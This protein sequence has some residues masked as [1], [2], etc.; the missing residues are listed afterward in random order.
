MSSDGIFPSAT[1]CMQ[2][3]CSITTPNL[4]KVLGS[5]VLT[6]VIGNSPLSTKSR[7]I[8]FSSKGSWLRFQL[9][10]FMYKLQNYSF[11]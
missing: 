10:L 1:C 8:V 3:P 4:R 6:G 11:D 5:P 2:Y 9:E 7:A